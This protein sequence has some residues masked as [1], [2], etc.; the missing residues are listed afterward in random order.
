MPAQS[1]HLAA[2]LLSLRRARR[3]SQ[4]RLADLAA[5]PRTT[6]AHMESGA[7][8][9]SLHNLSR[10]AHAL[11]VSIE[12]LLARPR[13]ACRL[14]KAADLQRQEQR[15]GDVLITDLLPEKV[16]GLEIVR[17]RLRPGSQRPGHP[18]LLG[19]HE[20]LHGLAGC[21]SVLLAGELYRVEQGDVLA[22]AG[23]QAH[24]YLN[25]DQALAEAISVVVPVNTLQL[26]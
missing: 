26:A 14:I 25:R 2:N 24:S 6:L 23:D 1:R 21:V 8:N 19:T 20:Y 13:Q 10:V 22:F 5:V 16:R 17:L 18:H 4:Q 9:P 11:N 7:G 3:W 15:S 12:E